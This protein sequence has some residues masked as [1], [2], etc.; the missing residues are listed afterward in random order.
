[1]RQALAVM[2]LGWLLVG[3][4]TLGHAA[5]AVLPAD[6][7]VQVTLGPDFGLLVVSGDGVR[8]LA[9]S[10]PAAALLVEAGAALPADTPARLAPLRRYVTGATVEGTRLRLALALGVEVVPTSLGRARLALDFRAA[11]TAPSEPAARSREPSRD[12]PTPLFPSKSARVAPAAGPETGAARSRERRPVP[13]PKPRPPA[14]PATDSAPSSAERPTPPPLVEP[15]AGPAA[16]APEAADPLAVTVAALADA[17]GAELRFAWPTAVPAAVFERSGALWAVF[18]AEPAVVRGWSE[19]AIGGLAGWAEPL[20]QRVVGDVQLFRLALRRPARVEAA[21]ESGE[22]RLRLLPPLRPDAAAPAAEGVTRDAATGA[23]RGKLPARVAEV[24]DPASGERLG[25]LLATA[26]DLRHPATV[27]LVDVELLASA[28]GLA[29]LPLSDGVAATAGEHGFALTRPGGLRLALQDHP[30]VPAAVPGKEHPRPADAS[31]PA[32]AEAAPTLPELP[33][34]FAALAGSTVRDRQEARSALAARMQRLQGLSRAVAGLDL[35]R[36][37]LADALAPEARTTLARIETAG[38]AQPAARAIDRS[39]AA[40]NGA[41]AALAGQGERALAAWREAGLEHER[42][43]EP[44]LWRAYAAARGGQHPL[45]AREWASTGTLLASYPDPLRRR[46]GRELAA[47]LAHHGDPK[48]ARALL[49]LLRPFETDPAGRAELQLLRGVAAARGKQPVIVEQALL[50]AQAQG[51]PGTKVEASFLLTVARHEQGELDTGAAVAELTAQR[52]RWH[53]HPWEPRMLRQ[54]AELQGV[55]GD[56]VGA[57]ATAVEL[58]ERPPAGASAGAAG[59]EAAARLA[60]VLAAAGDGRVSPVRA[61]AL[62]GTHGRLLDGDP[63]AP[64]LR[65]LLAR[66][67][68]EA[69]LPGTAQKLLERAG[70]AGPEGAVAVGAIAH[71]RLADG[72][73]SDRAM[74][75]AGRPDR[76]S[77]SEVDRQHLEV[78]AA[79]GDWVGVART[80]AA[81][82]E[83]RGPDE[84]LDAEAATA[85]VWQA[86]ARAQQGEPGEA[87]LLAARNDRRL[88]DGGPWRQLLGLIASTALAPGS[89]AEAPP[90]T[91]ALVQ[92]VRGHLGRLPPFGA[93]PRQPAEIKSAAERSAPAG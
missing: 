93:E 27:R 35:A 67:L 77:G 31:E 23:L 45:A 25:V 18:G 66:R 84:P 62:H 16:A 50:A 29:W 73:A 47:S 72:E 60:A 34:G 76:A 69:G 90:V 63:Q 5:P 52:P 33:L 85:L 8:L 32:A 17:K 48:Q 26:D 9:A 53:G 56:P 44:A 64:R 68:A 82:L 65:Q 57:F 86:L 55:A 2:L 87:A 51:D 59:S 3:P 43:P 78:L 20:E 75:T 15:Q 19:L 91:G 28:Q 24:E 11:A 7:R 12:A 30:T 10:N 70:T 61:A 21:R 49:D 4:A 14:Q 71:A 88:P 37:Q 89:A 83:R 40:L 22:W 36:L 1:V 81:T 79:V 39:R 41:A 80:A 58:L 92:A 38:L 42:E 74:P 54:L 6:A 46:L 13:V